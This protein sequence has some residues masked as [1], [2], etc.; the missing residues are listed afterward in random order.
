MADIVVL[1]NSGLSSSAERTRWKFGDDFLSSG[2][3]CLIS[4]FSSSSVV[5][6]GLRGVFV[7]Y[8]GR[9]GRQEGRW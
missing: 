1:Q 7:K 8:V 2:G 6:E 3:G 5:L 9:C 4:P